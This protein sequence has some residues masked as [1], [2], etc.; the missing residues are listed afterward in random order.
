MSTK[1][2]TFAPETT[3]LAGYTIKRGIQRGGFG[4]STTRTATGARKSP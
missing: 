2:F 1:K 3:P 4:R